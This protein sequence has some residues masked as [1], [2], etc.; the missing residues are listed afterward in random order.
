MA[1]RAEPALNVARDI[2]A[3]ILILVLANLES[4]KDLLSTVLTCSKIHQTFQF[5]ADQ[6]RLAVLYNEFSYDGVNMALGVVQ[7]PLSCRC[8]KKSLVAM[9]DCMNQPSALKAE[10]V[11]KFETTPNT[12]P[13]PKV[14]LQLKHW[15]SGHDFIGTPGS[16][17]HSKFISTHFNAVAAHLGAAR[18]LIEDYAYK[19]LQVGPPDV[20][21]HKHARDK[22]SV[23]PWFTAP[24]LSHV[25]RAAESNIFATFSLEERRRFLRAVMRFEMVKLIFTHTG[26]MDEC[27]RFLCMFPDVEVEQVRAVAEHSERLWYMLIFHVCEV[28][29]SSWE[30]NSFL[31]RKQ[32]GFASTERKELLRKF[33]IGAGGV[34]KYLGTS[35]HTLVHTLKTG[36]AEALDTEIWGDLFDGSPGGLHEDFFFS[37][38]HVIYRST[39]SQTRSRLARMRRQA[40]AAGDLASSGSSSSSLPSPVSNGFFEQYRDAVS[41]DPASSPWPALSTSSRRLEYLVRR[42]GYLFWDAKR[43]PN[44]TFTSKLKDSTG[45]GVRRSATV[46]WDDDD[47]PL[48]SVETKPNTETTEVSMQGFPFAESVVCDPVWTDR[49][50]AAS[51]RRVEKSKR[52]HRK[53]TLSAA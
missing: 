38:D 42:T 1:S 17:S 47:Q 26:S 46:V 9:E 3:E 41:A 15:H 2:P 13:C 4:R 16:K 37:L 36:D 28:P 25:A 20:S 23:L 22:A 29:V 51:R 44:L 43:A 8:N 18:A 34:G 5:A 52:R 35:L 11:R 12:K 30:P 21:A 24:H 31:R 48:L 10:L 32:V 7:F 19:S 50:S 14:K 53:R 49:L 40:G 6:V 45:P 39:N 27:A 33:K